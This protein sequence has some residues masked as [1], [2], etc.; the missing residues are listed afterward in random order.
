MLKSNRDKC[1]VDGIESLN[2]GCKGKLFKILILIVQVPLI[3]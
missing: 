3:N 1:P 2:E